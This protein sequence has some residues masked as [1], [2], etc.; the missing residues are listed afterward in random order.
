MK[1]IY[2][3]FALS[4]LLSNVKLAQGQIFYNNIV[5]KI[6]QRPS[7]YD[8]YL[9]RGIGT[10]PSDYL[11]R[12][13]K[14]DYKDTSYFRLRII[15]NYPN[16][17]VLCLN[18]TIV[19]ALS[20]GDA[21]D[22]VQTVWSSNKQNWM[23]LCNYQTIKFGQWQ[24]VSHK[25]IGIRMYK[26]GEYYYGYIQMSVAPNVAGQP[27]VTI[28]D[29]AYEQTPGKGIKAGQTVGINHL[30]LNNSNYILNNRQLN[31]ISEKAEKITLTDISGNQLLNSDVR[32]NKSF[33][34]SS[35]SN[36]IYILTITA[37]NGVITKKISL[38]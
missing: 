33:D 25:F 23:W 29:L 38:Q 15:P 27:D 3:L 37:S 5:D 1:K 30:V 10:I 31:I 4:L 14:T 17:E 32:T 24:T 6:V 8:V 11:I 12:E 7:T 13:D 9:L 19:K 16:Q 36:G 28:F 34:L 35:Y 26:N 18:D 22:D 20:T 2:F 21:I